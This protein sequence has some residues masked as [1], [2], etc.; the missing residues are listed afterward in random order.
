MAGLTYALQHG[1]SASMPAA[2]DVDWESVKT[3]AISVGARE[4]ARRMGLSEDAVRQ[5]CTREGWLR[6]L[7]RSTPLPTSVLRPVATVATASEALVASMREDA[8]RGRA[9]ALRSG[10]V[11]LERVAEMDAD[12]LITP[13]FADVANK[14]GKTHALAAGYG[15]GDGVQRLD[16]RLTTDRRAMEGVIE[17]E[18]VE[19]PGQQ[20]FEG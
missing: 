18:V 3:L 11:A 19:T 13:E 9:A 8:I 16:L 4:A 17:A 14:W 6:D 20:E 2:L 10:R 7:P 15:A 1:N 5:R 12:E